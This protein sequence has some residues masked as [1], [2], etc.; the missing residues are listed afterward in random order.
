MKRR[1]ILNMILVVVLML[2]LV[3]CQE[4]TN[5]KTDTQSIYFFDSVRGSLVSEPLSS[6]FYALTDNQEKVK[7]IIGRLKENKS[8]QTTILQAG[9]EMP[10]Q[11]TAIKERVV[12]IYFNEAYNELSIQDKIGM[13]ASLVY[14]LAELE[15]V[16]GV[17]FYVNETPLATTTGK[18][19]GT[20]YPSNINKEV[21]DPYPATTPYTLPVYFANK[22]GKLV[23]EEHSIRVS[24][25]NAV[26]KPLLEE[27]L[28]GPNSDELVLLNLL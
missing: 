7:Y 14:S 15:F 8:V 3:G 12:V 27:L 26:E 24:N 21:L 20:V 6:D 28:K 1:N 19:I 4:T 16:D 17:E 18:I 5:Q 2:S 25:P 10:I 13:R 11:N 23:K 22:D 9:P